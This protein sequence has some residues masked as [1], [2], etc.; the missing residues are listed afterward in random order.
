MIVTASIRL[1]PDL[2]PT[3]SWLRPRLLDRLG[4]GRRRQRG[5]AAHR[6][7]PRP[8]RQGAD[9]P[10]R[11][12]VHPQRSLRRLPTMPDRPAVT[13]AES[14]GSAARSVP[15]GGYD[16]PTEERISCRSCRSGTP[17]RRH[18]AESPLRKYSQ[19]R[20][21]TSYSVIRLVTLSRNKRNAAFRTRLSGTH[22]LSYYSERCLGSTGHWPVTELTRGRCWNQLFDAVPCRSSAE[23]GSSLS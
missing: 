1:L 15:R 19:A 4:T 7:R 17:V 10:G 20:S 2:H 14:P 23:P 11:G 8:R 6:I 13:W 18:P 21:T 16:R 5:H 22:N 9:R 3:L 12:T